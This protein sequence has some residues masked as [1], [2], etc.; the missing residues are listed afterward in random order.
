MQAL[1]KIVDSWVPEGKNKQRNVVF[2]VTSCK[3]S[4][5][6]NLGVLAKVELDNKEE[7]LAIIV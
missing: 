1:T 6:D 3:H 2:N 7:F 5:S 4:T